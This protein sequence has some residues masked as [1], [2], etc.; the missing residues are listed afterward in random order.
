M[1]HV[2]LPYDT[3]FVFAE[4]NGD[5]VY[6]DV[7]KDGS[8]KARTVD[9]HSVGSFIST[10]APGSKER[11]D[12]TEEYKYPDGKSAFWHMFLSLYSSICPPSS[13]SI[14]Q[15]VRR[16]VSQSVSQSGSQSVSQ[17]VRQSVRQSVSQSVSP[18]FR[19]SANRSVGLSVKH[20]GRQAGKE[21][22]RK[23]LGVFL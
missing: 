19:L 21:E 15:L 13:Q 7:K 1:G 14:S 10:K 2:Y 16:S 8:M 4:V 20:V 5:S 9:E 17:S 23:R 3:G 6:W 22:S 11:E 12:L 18:P